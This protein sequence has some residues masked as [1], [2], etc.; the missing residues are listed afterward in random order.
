MTE[1]TQKEEFNIEELVNDLQTIGNVVQQH[2]QS[3][4]QIIA[5]LNAL[6]NILLS[7]NVCSEDDMKEATEEEAKI[8]QE[9]IMQM[10]SQK[11]EDDSGNKEEEEK[12]KGCPDCG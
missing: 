2:D 4:F 8:L 10:V 11:S 5:S 7:K 6:Q 9:K 12:K 3:I 1:N